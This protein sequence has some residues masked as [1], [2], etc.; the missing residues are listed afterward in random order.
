[1]TWTA[2]ERDCR[3]LWG[4]G[5]EGEFLRL[6]QYGKRTLRRW[7]SAGHVKGP[8]VREM[9]DAFKKLK[10]AGEPLP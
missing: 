4:D 2:F 3:F 6:A 10:A 7:R 8:A 9:L 5:W 1:M